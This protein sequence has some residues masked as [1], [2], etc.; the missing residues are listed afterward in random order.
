MPDSVAPLGRWAAITA[1]SVVW[2]YP[3]LLAA[4]GPGPPDPEMCTAATMRF[5]NNP[6]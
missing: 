4:V 5:G 6:L 2:L 1:P 3:F